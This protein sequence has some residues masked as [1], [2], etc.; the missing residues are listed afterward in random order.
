M[1][2]EN[3]CIKHVYNM[4]LQDIDMMPEKENW[5]VLVKRLLGSLGFNEVW[6][7]Q[8]V[9]NVN[10][11]QNLVKQRLQDHFIQAWNSR[12]EDTSRAN[13]YARI[14]SFQFQLDII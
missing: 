4:M 6:L 1:C 12:L 13:F 7:A 5:A 2:N 10:I 3:K 14:N 9:G 8:G 11:F